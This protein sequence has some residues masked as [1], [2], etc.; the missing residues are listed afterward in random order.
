MS[1]RKMYQD[2]SDYQILE[3]ANNWYGEHLGHPVDR[4]HKKKRFQ[5]SWKRDEIEELIG[6]ITLLEMMVK[7]NNYEEP[8]ATRNELYKDCIEILLNDWDLVLPVGV[9]YLSLTNTDKREILSDVAAH[10]YESDVFERISRYLISERDIELIVA[11]KLGRF[12]GIDACYLSRQVVGQIKLRDGILH[13][14]GE[15]YIGFA[16]QRFFEY[17]LAQHFVSQF[18]KMELNVDDICNLFVKHSS[19]ERWHGML[20]LLAGAIDISFVPKIVKSL[21]SLDGDK[22]EYHNVFLAARCIAELKWWNE[23]SDS[24]SPLQEQL[25]LLIRKPTFQSKALD[26][27]KSVE[28]RVL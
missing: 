26:A 3:F 5:E 12:D 17:C 28:K 19:D 20:S 18:W 8:P 14:A 21:L 23:I 10:I 22:Q 25:V 4:E 2:L 9:R 7:L 1:F 6:N 15:R 11:K 16:H 24:V 27:L 13:D